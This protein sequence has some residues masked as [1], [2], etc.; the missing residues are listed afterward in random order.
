M[1]SLV[2]TTVN[3]NLNFETAGQ[4]LTFYGGGETEHSISSRNSSG[5]AADDLRIN[6]F[7]ALFINLD[8]NNNNTSGADFSIGRHGQTGAI[9]DWLLDLSGETGK[10]T[11]SK[12][13]SGTHTGTLA[14]SLGVDSSGNVIEFTGLATPSSV[15]ISISK[16]VPK[17]SL[18]NTA[19]NSKT[20]SILGNG[21]SFYI[22]EAGV[23][24]R[25][26]IQAGGNVTF[27]SNVFRVQSASSTDMLVRINSGSSEVDSRLMIGEG[28]NYGMTLEYDGVA[29]IGYLGMNDNVAPTGAWSKRIQMSRGGTEVA[30][31]AG[32]VGIGTA[33]PTASDWNASAKLLEIFQNDTNGSILKVRSSNTNS[34]W[35]AGNAH[36]QI[37]TISSHPIKIYTGATQRVTILANGDIN[38]VGASNTNLFL[39]DASADSIGIGG[40]PASDS[41][42][43]VTGS[44][45]YP[46]RVQTTNGQYYF[47]DSV[48]Y[49]NS[50]NGMYLVN[51]SSHLA[52]GA[53]NAEVMRLTGGKVGIGTVSPAQMLSVWQ[54]RIGVSDAYNIGNLDRNTCLLYTSP[55]P[56]DS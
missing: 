10:L 52:L 3:G 13:G 32:Y 53:N 45:T 21:T 11:L 22:T 33:T 31:M 43:Y 4:Y 19:A 56:R 55:S 24:D 30:F 23:A 29:N 28:D 26:L 42:L 38:M 47:A 5:N 16:S 40:A 2:T 48:I 1:A 50:A 51:Q 39:L 20:W 15:D 46:L 7:G 14:K 34:F 35:A 8:S 9:T 54:G 41:S 17:F 49:A 27:T 25:L 36:L 12:Y 37:G 44:K 6:T 18:V